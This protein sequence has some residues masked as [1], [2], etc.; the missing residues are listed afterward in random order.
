MTPAPTRT[1]HISAKPDLGAT[2]PYVPLGRMTD[3][4]VCTILRSCALISFVSALNKSKPAEF[5]VGRFGVNA[6]KDNFLNFNIV[7]SCFFLVAVYSIHC[8]SILSQSS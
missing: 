8:T 2:L 6:L 4:S 5:N 3:M 1:K 7:L